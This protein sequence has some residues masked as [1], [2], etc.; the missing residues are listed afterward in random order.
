[1]ISILYACYHTKAVRFGPKYIQEDKFIVSYPLYITYNF[2]SVQTEPNRALLL[3]Q[4]P[5]SKGVW[6][7]IT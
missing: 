5:K 3:F 1:M 7:N 6:L 4:F 2:C